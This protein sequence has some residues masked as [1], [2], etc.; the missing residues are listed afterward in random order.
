[1][2]TN[3]SLGIFWTFER[4]DDIGH[5]IKYQDEVD[6]L[7]FYGHWKD[8]CPNE[9]ALDSFIGLWKGAN[10]QARLTKWDDENYRCYS[11]D[12]RIEKWPND[13]Q[14]KAYIECSLQWFVAQGAVV[15]WCGN[16]DCSPS[17]DVF[18]PDLSPGSI[19]AAYTPE[20][21]F[22][23]NSASLHDEYQELQDK[24]LLQVKYV[25]I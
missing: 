19:Y 8:K 16:E 24:Q 23:C 13:D 5:V 3:Q 11:L 18:N 4:L 20:T 25:L 17:L 21:G 1:M 12:V 9:L 10:I 7:T 6:G 2:K 15:S 14:W 22:L